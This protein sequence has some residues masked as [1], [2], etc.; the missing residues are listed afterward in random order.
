MRGMNGKHASPIRPARE[1]VTTAVETAQQAPQAATLDWDVANVAAQ[2][3][4]RAQCPDLSEIQVR[5]KGKMIA[6][7][8]L[9]ALGS[10]VQEVRAEAWDEGYGTDEECGMPRQNPYRADGGNS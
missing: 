10:V 1:D 5:H 4:L 6:R 8:V 9:S 2:N 7:A 3:Q